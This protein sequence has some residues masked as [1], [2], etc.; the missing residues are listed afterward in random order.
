MKKMLDWVA[1]H[2]RQLMRPDDGATIY[3]T[4]ARSVHDFMKVG[5]DLMID[6]VDVEDR[7]FDRA[8]DTGIKSFDA[9]LRKNQGTF[10][11]G[12]VWGDAQVSGF[13]RGVNNLAC[14]DKQFSPGELRKA[15]LKLFDRFSHQFNPIKT[16]LDRHPDVEVIVYAFRN[17]V[18]KPAVGSG[19]SPVWR[20]YGFLIT[21]INHNLLYR[22]YDGADRK[23]GD[24]LNEAEHFLTVNHQRNP[25]PLVRIKEGDLHIFNAEVQEAYDTLI[26]NERV[27]STLSERP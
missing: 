24:V 14:N 2:D 26:E 6:T 7:V 19:D 8:H 17:L 25:T 4:A 10:I 12:N 11:T 22:H 5:T 27:R 15:D 20:N 18:K 3:E 1:P 23:A 16:W 21:N 13:V 9:L